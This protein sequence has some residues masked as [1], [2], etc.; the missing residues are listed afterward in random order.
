MAFRANGGSLQR[1]DGSAPENYTTIADVMSVSG[2]GR[3]TNTVETTPLDETDQTFIVTTTD[4]GSFSGEG[5]FN[6]A[7]FQTLNTDLT[8]GTFNM[9][10]L[11]VVDAAGGDYAYIVG[12]GVP[13]GLEMSAQNGDKV[14]ASFEIKL[15]GAITVTAA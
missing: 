9:Y 4:N 15:S 3:Q 10:R 2:P 5:N 14:N 13:V 11:V 8:N 6:L 7:E 12:S 1:G